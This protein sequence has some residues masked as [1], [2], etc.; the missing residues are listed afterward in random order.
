MTLLHRI[1]QRTEVIKERLKLNKQFNISDPTLLDA[2]Q[3]EDFDEEGL[4]IMN[5]TD[6]NPWNL[7]SRGIS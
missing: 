4:N 3:F 1:Y 7:A 2:W 6:S 5:E